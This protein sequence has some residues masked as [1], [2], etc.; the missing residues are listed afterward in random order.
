MEYS[1]EDR[2]DDSGDLEKETETSSSEEEEDE[3]QMT[4]KLPHK[5]FDIRESASRASS[6]RMS[7]LASR[8]RAPLLDSNAHRSRRLTTDQDQVSVSDL[9]QGPR[10]IYGMVIAP[11]EKFMDAEKK[12]EKA[13]N[14]NL[15]L[16]SLEARR[17]TYHTP[18]RPDP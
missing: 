2:T 9:S 4:K 6:Q 1:K 16:K 8:G 13:R 17:C 18:F 10:T 12:Q 11:D 14:T 3:V 7:V 5:G 15:D